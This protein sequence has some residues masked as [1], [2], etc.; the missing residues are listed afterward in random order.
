MSY[1]FFFQA[2]DGIRDYKVTGVQTCALPISRSRK[3]SRTRHRRP[4][5][6]ISSWKAAITRLACSNPAAAIR[7]SSM[8]RFR[9]S[10]RPGSL[11]RSRRLMVAITQLDGFALL[12]RP[13]VDHLDEHR[14]AHREVD[15]PLRDV[16]SEAIGDERH[17]N[18]QQEAQRQHL[19]GG[20]RLDEGAH[21]TGREHHD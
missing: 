2:E 5:S 20:M 4:R 7:S 11:S 16:E 15:V 17:A 1:F 14:E 12:L 18:Q 19:D 21:R 13:Q 9:T 6:S 8:P 10:S 3:R